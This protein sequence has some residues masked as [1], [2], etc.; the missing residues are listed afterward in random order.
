M[1]LGEGGGGFAEPQPL[2]P[3]AGRL[4]RIP[5]APGVMAEMLRHRLVRAPH[6]ALHA[7]D[8]AA[9]GLAFKLGGQALPGG[10]ILQPPGP[11][12]RRI[13]PA[14]INGPPQLIGKEGFH[15]LPE[16]RRSAGS[17]GHGT[18]FSQATGELLAL[19][20]DQ[21]REPADQGVGIAGMP[22]AAALLAATLSGSQ[23]EGGRQSVLAHN[24]DRGEEDRE[25]DRPV[26]AGAAH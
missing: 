2:Q 16:L 10:E 13:A 7:G 23:P 5:G 17:G 4:D 18:E 1:G 26:M 21:L 3:L 8:I 11:A 19:Q 25:G 14:V 24:P 9:D 6:R 22:D 20:I 15:V 12:C